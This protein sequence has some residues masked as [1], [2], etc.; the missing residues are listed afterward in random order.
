PVLATEAPALQATARIGEDLLAPPAV[1]FQDV[2]INGLKIAGQAPEIDVAEHAGKLVS[3]GPGA[4]APSV[5]EAQGAA[6][7]EKASRKLRP[8]T[9]VAA[10]GQAQNRIRRRVTAANAVAARRHPQQN[11]DPGIL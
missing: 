1:V 5:G 9:D 11:R 7:R 4:T 3:A 6:A 8:A 10:V 2:Q